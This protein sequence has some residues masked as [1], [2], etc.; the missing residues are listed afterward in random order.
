MMADDWDVEVT[1]KPSEDAYADYR[2]LRHLPQVVEHITNL[3]AQ[4]Q[5]GTL[6]PDDFE[7]RVQNDAGTQRAR[8]LVKPANS[9]GFKLELRD[10]VLIKATAGMAG[11]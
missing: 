10:S 2:M 11:R 6:A 3:A 4:I 1:T 5:Q 8:A 7:I 9:A